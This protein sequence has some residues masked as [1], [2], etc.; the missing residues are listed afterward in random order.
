MVLVEDVVEL[1]VRL[2]QLD[3][4]GIL[5]VRLALH[6]GV[7]VCESTL[8]LFL[9]AGRESDGDLDLISGGLASHC[10]AREPVIIV[11]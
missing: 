5:L 6:G 7:W 10:L 4:E 1:R 2:L 9:Q 11:K 8:L 3:E